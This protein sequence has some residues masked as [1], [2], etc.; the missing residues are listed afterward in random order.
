M[1]DVMSSLYKT[2]F[3]QKEKLFVGISYIPKTTVQAANGAISFSLGFVH[4]Q[5]MLSIAVLSI[6]ITAPTGAFLMYLS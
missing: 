2:S 3:K 5:L 6:V 4:G 1:I